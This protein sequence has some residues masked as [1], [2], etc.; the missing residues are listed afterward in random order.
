MQSPGLPV[1][2]ICPCLHAWATAWAEEASTHKPARTAAREKPWS[3]ILVSLRRSSGTRTLRYALPF[4]GDIRSSSDCTWFSGIV[5]ILRLIL[6][7]PS[8]IVKLRSGLD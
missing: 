6:L 3:V 7:H 8:W 1:Q 4:L 2:F 5:E